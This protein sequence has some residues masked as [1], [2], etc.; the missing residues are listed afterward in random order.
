[1]NREER[2]VFEYY[3]R[4]KDT[5][6][7]RFEDNADINGMNKDK[8]FRITTGSRPSDFI[9]IERGHMFFAEVKGTTQSKFSTGLI[10]QSQLNAAKKI[11][12]AGGSYIFIVY[13]QK[14]NSWYHIPYIKALHSS[15]WVD[16]ET[17]KVNIYGE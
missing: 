13:S 12:T 7:I 5:C 15:S 17:Y 1:M 11:T 4:N 6:C 10:R 16:L 9:V 3:N 14:T 2:V 8:K